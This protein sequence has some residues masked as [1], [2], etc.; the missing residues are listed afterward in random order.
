MTFEWSAGWWFGSSTANGWRQMTSERQAAHGRRRMSGKKDRPSICCCE[1]VAKGVAG[2]TTTR[3]SSRWRQGKADACN[4]RAPPRRAGARAA[5]QGASRPAARRL[6]TSALARLLGRSERSASV[7][8]VKGLVSGSACA[9]W[10]WNHA[11]W[12]ERG[13][14]GGGVWRGARRGRGGRRGAGHL[15]RTRRSGLRSRRAHL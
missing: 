8:P 1:L 15:P 11:A 5:A 3:G 10:Q 13:G 4:R 9:V 12:E 6:S 7:C 14:E 2:R